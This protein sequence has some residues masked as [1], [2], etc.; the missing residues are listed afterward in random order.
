MYT[1]V[2]GHEKQW[3]DRTSANIGLPSRVIAE[4]LKSPQ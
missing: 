3:K 2:C 4:T 1:V